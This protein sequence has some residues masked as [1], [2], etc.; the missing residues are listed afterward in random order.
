MSKSGS[1]AKV[2]DID[3]LSIIVDS[4]IQPR[5]NTL[6]QSHVEDL[7]EAY[8]AKADIPPITVWK[9]PNGH[10]KLSQGF[11]RLEAANRAGMQKIPA[12]I[13]VGTEKDCLI[14]A[15]CSNQ[16][17]G[18]KRT[19]EDKRR[20]VVE[21]LKVL[22]DKSDR[23]IAE[24]A[25]VGHV[26]VG[27]LR[28]TTEQSNDASGFKNQMVDKNIGLTGDGKQGLSNDASDNCYQIAGK[29]VGASAIDF[30]SQADNQ[31]DVTAEKPTAKPVKTR[32]GKDGVSR[33]VPER[34]SPASK[35]TKAPEPVSLPGAD[36]GQEEQP[37]SDPVAEQVQE[38]PEAVP[39]DPGDEFVSQVESLCR[40]MD[41][42]KARING[43]KQSPYSYSMHVDS[44]AMSV[45]AARKTLWT[46]RPKCVCPYCRADGRVNKEC[47]SCRGT[48][49][50]KKSSYDA[51]V[52][53]VGMG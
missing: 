50:V 48:N 34:S 39:G 23:N 15:M 24:M 42:I 12:I 16:G 2:F 31:T 11:H 9:L 51:G 22:H 4:S 25:G 27:K 28:A 13:K 45:E 18:L 52:E 44:A 35:P 46:G 10:N 7:K 33:K 20:C 6:D 37:Y 29:N 49:R 17:H 8:L 26:F 5:A 1:P 32:T 3:L 14:D 41:Q 36:E 53:A 19:N 21:L 43:L 47:R 30:D 38:E 40:D